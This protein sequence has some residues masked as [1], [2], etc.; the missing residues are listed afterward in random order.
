VNI[1]RVPRQNNFGAVN[2]RTHQSRGKKK[3][4]CEPQKKSQGFL[5]VC[6]SILL[7]RAR[8]LLAQTKKK[9]MKILFLT[10]HMLAF[11]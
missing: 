8:V 5:L 10:S 9:P 1:V 11:F 4:G 6:A 2:E 7:A 3:E